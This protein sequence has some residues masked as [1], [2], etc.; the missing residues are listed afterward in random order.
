[1]LSGESPAQAACIA[2]DYV[3]E[4]YTDQ[5]SS[6]SKLQRHVVGWPGLTAKG[7]FTSPCAGDPGSG[8]GAEI[9]CIAF[10]L[11]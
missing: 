7:S 1:V 3:G 4:G 9:L 5:T 11:L 6:L 10:F 2:L 8:W